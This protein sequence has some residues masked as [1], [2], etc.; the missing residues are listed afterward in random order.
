MTAGCF[1]I[2]KKRRDEMNKKT[3]HMC[4]LGALAEKAGQTNK[5]AA[6]PAMEKEELV[7]VYN[8]FYRNQ[9]S[10]LYRAIHTDK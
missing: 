1:L 5:R 4:R 9:L 2:K 10:A 8:K 6:K 3:V 7:T